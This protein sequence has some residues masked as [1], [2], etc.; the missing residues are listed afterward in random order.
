MT[1]PAAPRFREVRRSNGARVAPR[2]VA[3]QGDGKGARA[4]AGCRSMAG[5]AV[6]VGWSPRPALG[7]PCPRPAARVGDGRGG[8]GPPAESRVGNRQPRGACAQR[9]AYAPFRGR[10]APP[11]TA[12]RSSCSRASRGERRQTPFPFP[13]QRGP[14]AAYD[15]IAVLR[16]RL[17]RGQPC[18]TQHSGWGPEGAHG[19]S[20]AARSKAAEEFGG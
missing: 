1:R 7:L 12:A 8:A 5:V 19:I 4:A 16:L 20:T 6:G 14:L 10:F 18:S 2:Q 17:R 15:T 11:R 13:I 9:E 3:R